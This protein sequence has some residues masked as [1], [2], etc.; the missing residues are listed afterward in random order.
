MYASFFSGFLLSFHIFI[1]LE[2]KFNFKEVWEK[3]YE[4][5]EAKVRDGASCCEWIFLATKVYTSE[6]SCPL[7]IPPIFYWQL[8]FVVLQL[9]ENA[10][11]ICAWDA[12][13]CARRKLKRFTRGRKE[14]RGSKWT[15]MGYFGQIRIVSQFTMNGFS[16]K[17]LMNKLTIGWWCSFMIWAVVG[18]VVVGICRMFVCWCCW[19]GC[20]AVIWVVVMPMMF[21]C[22]FVWW[23]TTDVVVFGDCWGTVAGTGLFAAF[24]CFALGDTALPKL[25]ALRPR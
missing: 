9:I 18:V 20:W 22:W 15:F 7:T 17:N 6:N 8:I 23:L 25:R 2:F 14:E 19:C 3:K 13:K 4:R 11:L 21:D 10:Q 5:W 24:C 16:L 1:F 12:R